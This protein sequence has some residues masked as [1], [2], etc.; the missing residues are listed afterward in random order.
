MRLLL[1]KVDGT[2]KCWCVKIFKSVKEL[3]NLFPKVSY[4][5]WSYWYQ[6]PT[7]PAWWCILKSSAKWW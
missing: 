2:I 1:L 3:Q 5:F 7:T 6:C 4:I